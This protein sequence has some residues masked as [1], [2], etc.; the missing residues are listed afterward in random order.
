MTGVYSSYLRPSSPW[1]ERQEFQGE[2]EITPDE[3]KEE[4]KSED[5]DED[6][7]AGSENGNIFKHRNA[8]AVSILSTRDEYLKYHQENPGFFSTVLDTRNMEESKDIIEELVLEMLEEFRNDES[9][10]KNYPLVESYARKSSF[11]SL[12][13]LLI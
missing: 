12:M 3:N 6:L 7:G 10:T 9:N 1:Y 2:V 8:M 4:N 11:S 13:S 5:E